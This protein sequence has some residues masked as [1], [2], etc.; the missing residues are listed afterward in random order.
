[1]APG[2]QY[3]RLAAVQF[4]VDQI[5]HLSHRL[6]GRRGLLDNTMTNL[7]EDLLNVAIHFLAI[8]RHTP[9]KETKAF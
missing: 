8:H 9:E 4:P 2:L 6:Q 5:L 1:M 7:L 3:L